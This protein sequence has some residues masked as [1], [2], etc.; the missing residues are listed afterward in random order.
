MPKPKG[1]RGHAAP[2]DTKLIRIPVPLADQVQQLVERYRDFIAGGGE[3][4]APPPLLDA[5]ASD[6][7][8]NNFDELLKAE[9]EEL[10]GEINFQQNRWELTERHNNGLAKECQALELQ[11]EQL[12]LE[13]DQLDHEINELHQKNG[14]LNLE[15]EI[16]RQQLKDAA[17]PV[18]EFELKEARATAEYWQARAEDSERKHLKAVN[19][20]SDIKDEPE[21]SALSKSELLSLTG[22]KELQPALNLHEGKRIVISPN[23]NDTYKNQPGVITGFTSTS[24]KVRLDNGMEEDF[25]NV[26]LYEPIDNT[27]YKAVNNLLQPLSQRQL[28]KRLGLSHTAIGKKQKQL[29][30]LA[31]WTRERDPEGI[32]WE[33]DATSKLFQP[34]K[35]Q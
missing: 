24:V 26:S 9:V 23:C 4:F 8:V 17:N 14:D 15:V 21:S 5:I 30:S 19:K 29:T 2:Y 16:L 11:L 20:L 25:S 12:K 27:S 28:A 13:R 22:Q 31:E 35:L 33:Y 34:L 32:A 18:N 1:G 3:A 7:P 6:N 10:H